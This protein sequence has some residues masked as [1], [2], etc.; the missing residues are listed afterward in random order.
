MARYLVGKK[1]V[2]K[3]TWGF[4][5]A[6]EAANDGDVIELEAGFSPFYEQN[7]Q[8]V[9]ITK[10]ITIEGH[11]VQDEKSGGF[12]INVIDGVFVT[13]G[14]V[15]TLKDLE[16]R[17][18]I[19]K[20][21]N[22]NV[23]E[24]STLIAEDVLLTSYAAEGKNYP[25]IYIGNKS[26]VT[27]INSII[28]PGNLHDRNYKV[29]AQDSKLEI[30]NSTINAMISVSNSK[31][32]IQ[33][34]LVSYQESNVLF[35]EKNSI[36]TTEGTIFEGGYKMEKET[37]PCIKLI[38]SQLTAVDIMVKQPKYNM[39]LKTINTKVTL[40]IGRYDSLYFDKSEVSIGN[41]G[42]VESVAICNG[43]HVKAEG[44]GIFGKENGKINLYVG[45][46][47][48][49]EA[50]AVY[51]GRLSKPN[52]K[53]E[54]NSTINVDEMMQVE[55]NPEDG[56]FVINEDETLT[57]IADAPEIEYYG[58]MSAF[59]RLNQ[60]TGI[61]SA[62]AAVEEFVAIAEMYKKREKQGLKNS[63][64]SLHSLFLGNPGT[65]KTTVARLVGEILYEKG[66]ISSQNF[67][68][69]SRSDLVGQY[70][71]ETAIKT[72]K[73]LESALGGVLFIDEA[74][75]LWTGPDNSKDFGIEAINELLKFMED[76]R[77]DIVLIFAGYTHSMEKFLE[78]NEGLKS[79]IPNTFIFED[80]TE[81][82]LIQIGLGDLHEQKYEIDENAYAELVYREYSESNDKS[83]GRWVRNLN[84]KLIRKMA[85]RVSRNSN[86]NLMLITQEDIDAI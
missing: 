8:H 12:L 6:I 27:L 24:G 7:N 73:I 43:S 1:G 13:K 33:N 77:Q 45:E 61:S 19:D 40:N 22:I 11:T 32:D 70:I 53:V 60:M 52:T 57:I 85:V 34:S 23:K 29:Y 66:I 37:W 63:A 75:T 64:F 26:Q 25:V 31:V 69:T 58:K 39:A 54:R 30:I 42:A 17:R 4:T 2:L 74:Y 38:D 50:G 20:C 21:N 67:V 15:V 46:K 5:Q 48:S 55:H 65:G 18:N 16:V 78:S 56:E 84:E 3:Q 36:I 59:E 44:I 80:Y 47:S 62:K 83:N 41:I 28:D 35:A 49:L 10:N 79:R 71:G 86:A 76:H 72:R 9:T 81:E 82:E 51:F 14:A 68:E